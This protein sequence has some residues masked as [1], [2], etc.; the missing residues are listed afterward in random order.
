MFLILFI[1]IAQS[2]SVSSAFGIMCIFDAC[3]DNFCM[4]FQIPQYNSLNCATTK[5]D[6]CE[7]EQYHHYLMKVEV[8]V[9]AVGVPGDHP[10]PSH[11][12]SQ[13]AQVSC[14]ITILPCSQCS[15][16]SQT[17]CGSH[18]NSDGESKLIFS[19]VKTQVIPF[20]SSQQ[21]LQSALEEFY[22]R[23]MYWQEERNL[24]ITYGASVN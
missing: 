3:L 10:G 5:S 8:L 9:G 13:G 7:T 11:C 16:S 19:D 22:L 23:N 6:L 21:H 2:C 12:P 17:P 24:L 4:F 15:C 14:C 20:L 1:C 18:R